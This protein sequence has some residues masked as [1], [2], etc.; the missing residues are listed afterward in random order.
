MANSLLLLMDYD[1]L[2]T[3]DHFT[4]NR[5]YKEAARI[6]HK[7]NSELLLA[8]LSLSDTVNLYPIHYLKISSVPIIKMLKSLGGAM[9]V[10]DY[11]GPYDAQAMLK[12]LVNYHPTNEFNGEAT[13][14]SM[15]VM[16]TGWGTDYFIKAHVQPNVF[17]AQVGD[18][19]ADHQCWMRPEDMT[20]PRTSY[21]IDPSHPGSD[22]AGETAA[23]LAAASLAFKRTDPKYAKLLM[24]HSWQL[25]EFAKSH[26]G[27]YS[28]SIPQ[29]HFYSSSG[30]ED[31]LV[32]A[33]AWI[34]RATKN[35]YALSYLQSANTGGTR[36]AFSWDDKYSGAQILV[37][38]LIE[39]GFVSGQGNMGTLKYQGE[40][41]LC[42]LVGKGNNNVKRTPGGGLY[43]MP[44]NDLQYTTSALFLA[45]T[46]AKTLKYKRTSLRCNG[47]YVSSHD[48]VSF[49]KYQVDY[50]LG[51][52]P[53]R[54]SYMVGYGPKYP[55]KVHHRGASIVSIKKDKRLVTCQ[56]GFNAWFYNKSPNPN[57]LHGAIV[58][59]P[60]Q[61][62]NYEDSRT[63]F[64]QNEAATANTASFVGVLALL[65]SS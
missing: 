48:L 40:Q 57:V 27:K 7:E 42:N 30:F 46:Y 65:A 23:A 8:K 52:N 26:Q 13:Q 64:D 9:E 25:F 10:E 50:I 56:G 15:M 20:T 4:F 21:K 31:E 51:N 49:V 12:G 47:G 19:D 3:L 35:K 58:G 16:T 33:A 14:P 17:Y 62:D 63:N 5:V 6:L 29:A 37:G 28:D 32:W 22:L 38:Q 45:S 53:K 61:N 39:L 2:M 18:G 34:Y 60:D 36:S 41:F 1:G 24:S 44:Q 59:G 11:N 54:M 55:V 43:W